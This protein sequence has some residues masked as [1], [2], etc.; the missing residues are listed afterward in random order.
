MVGF[1]LLARRVARAFRVVVG[2]P[3][4]RA[5]GSLLLLLLA[6]GTVF[7]RQVEEWSWVDSIYFCVVTLSTVGYGDFAPTTDGGKLF[8]IFYIFMGIS[9]LVGFGSKMMQGL[10]GSRRRGAGSSSDVE[11]LKP[12]G[13]ASQG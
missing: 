2:D 13:K 4:F 3:E 1:L 12:A 5:L 10:L 6:I 8:T 11:A 7:Y 9:V